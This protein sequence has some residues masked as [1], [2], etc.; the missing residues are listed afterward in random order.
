MNLL[1]ETS[2]RGHLSGREQRYKFLPDGRAR[3]KEET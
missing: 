3:R 1:P 2:R